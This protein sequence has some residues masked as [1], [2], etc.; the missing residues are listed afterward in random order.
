[1]ASVLTRFGME[2]DQA[3]ESRMVSRRIEAAQKKVEE[4]NFDIRKN[5]L[6]YDEVMDHQRKR[7]YGY[8]QEI[9]E[10][11]NC[12]LLIITMMDEQIAKAVEKFLDANYGMD[13]FAEFASKRLGLELSPSTFYRCTFTE[14]VQVAKER[15]TNAVP[16]QIHEMMEENLSTDVEEKEWNWQA[17]ASQANN[18]WGLKLTDRE[19][20]KIGRDNLSTF[21]IEQ[22]EKSIGE[23][24]LSGGQSFLEPTWGVQSIVDWVRNKFGIK[25]DPAGLKDKEAD[26][27]LAMVRG[28]VLDVYRQKEVEFPVK[29]AMA[30]FMSDRGHSGPAGQRYDREGLFQWCQSRFP[31]AG[32]TED[33]FRTEPRA[34]I[35]EKL[36]EV[37]KAAF[38]Q[39]TQEEIND[40][41]T[42]S[43]R[44]TTQ[45]EEADAQELAEWMKAELKLD[46]AV[47][48][49]TDVDVEEARQIL[50]D[51]FD[52]RYRP[53][54]RRVE[55]SLLLNQLDTS[56]KN[57]LYTM[58]HLRQGIGLMGYAQEDPKTAYKREGMREFDAMWDTLYDKVTDTI[59]RMEEEEGFQES[60][61]NIGA[62]VH[63]EAQ[64]VIAKGGEEDIRA[65]QNAA[66]SNSQKGEKKQEPIRKNPK[67]KVG[68]NDPCPCGSGKKYKNC[69]MRQAVG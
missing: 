29:V 64:S 37:S 58:D 30:R 15:A 43:F 31:E 19:L 63:E 12:K 69:H 27:I 62:T 26:D 50:W 39:A 67:E 57:H 66:I 6:E 22:A 28:Q 38:P 56:W 16:T 42:E 21:L 5:L 3:I 32:L 55:R 9:L 35:H 65:Q 10:G 1:V 4:R 47:E 7:L 49:L 23:V 48:D 17:M 13:C 33:F 60:L 61:W 18:R 20:K 68:R 24:D 2:E 45:S 25:I 11:A 41:L 54:M 8:R 34:K 52:R 46:V 59:L 51:A 44:G 14:A 36:L 53:E 40:R